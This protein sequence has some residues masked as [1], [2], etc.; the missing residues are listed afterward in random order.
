MIIQTSLQLR[1][2]IS[3]LLLEI[4][5]SIS[6]CISEIVGKHPAG[7][8]SHLTKTRNC[9][10]S[11]HLCEEPTCFGDDLF[12]RGFLSFISMSR[13][14][15]ADGFYYGLACVDGSDAREPYLDLLVNL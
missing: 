6:E 4:Q 13:H 15:W 1:A 5:T 14:P 10:N 2:F 11:H 3:P 8:W 7:N 9:H 12:I